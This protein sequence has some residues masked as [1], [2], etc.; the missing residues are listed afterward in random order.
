MKYLFINSVA[1]FGS[2]GRIAA[3]KCRELMSIR[4]MQKRRENVG[5]REH[6]TKKRKACK[7]GR[8]GQYANEF[9]KFFHHRISLSEAY[10]LCYECY[11]I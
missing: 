4:K 11:F 8:E 5:A 6:D 9:A 3:E 10:M 7:Q 2:T 1:G